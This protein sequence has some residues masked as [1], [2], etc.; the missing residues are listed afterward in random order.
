MKKEQDKE[1]REAREARE[2]AQNLM[3]QVGIFNTAEGCFGGLVGGD[4]WYA[5]KCKLVS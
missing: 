3:Q 5:E 1:A 4:R 2:N